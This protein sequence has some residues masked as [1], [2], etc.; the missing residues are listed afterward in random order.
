MAAMFEKHKHNNDLKYIYISVK[1]G[2]KKKPQILLIYIINFEVHKYIA[3][4]V[5]KY[6]NIWRVK[7]Q[8]ANDQN[9]SFPLNKIVL[10]S[11]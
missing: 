1:F 8:K 4:N 11:L 10:K 9:C 7:T 5:L 6:I 2:G 3:M